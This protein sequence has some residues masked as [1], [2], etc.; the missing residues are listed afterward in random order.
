[1]SSTEENVELIEL[2]SPSSTKSF[3]KSKLK[4]LDNKVGSSPKSSPAHSISKDS[5]GKIAKIPPA[6][7]PR[8]FVRRQ[9]KT[10]TE[11]SSDSQ[12]ESTDFKEY[13]ESI[14]SSKLESGSYRDKFKER[15]EYVKKQAGKSISKA[16]TFKSKGDRIKT[17]KKSFNVIKRQNDIIDAEL[18]TYE[19][20]KFCYDNENYVSSTEAYNF[21]CREQ[22]DEEKKLVES[23]NTLH[24]S[25]D[26]LIDINDAEDVL[27]C[28]PNNLQFN[29]VVS[30]NELFWQP[31]R[32]PLDVVKKIETDEPRFLSEEGFYKKVQ[33]N[34]PSSHINIIEQRLLGINDKKW[35][36]CEGQL[37]LLE[38]PKHEVRYKPHLYKKN[39]EL[40]TKYVK[41]TTDH[42]TREIYSSEAS[43]LDVSL[44]EIK[45]KHHPLFSPE[46]VFAQK[47]LTHFECYKRIIS[48]NKIERISKRLQALR[49]TK[50]NAY[51]ANDSSKFIEIKELREL[52]FTEGRNMRILIKSILQTW[53]ALKKIRH[54]NEYRSTTVQLVI[55]KT[56]ISY[57]S[58]KENWDTNIEN[59]TKEILEEKQIEYENRL[60]EYSRELNQ[61]KQEGDN[62][63]KPRKPS[64]QIDAETI[65]Q[66]VTELFMASFKPPGEPLLHF[67]IKY[68]QQ[69]S[70]KVDNAKEKLRRNVVNT[71]KIYLRVLCDKLEVCKSKIIPLNDQFV[72]TVDEYFSILLQTIPESI[73]VEIYEQPNTLPKRK[74]GEV[75]IRVPKK[76]VFANNSRGLDLDFGRDEI[77][78]YKHDGVGS[79]IELG[80][81]FSEYHQSNETLYTS[82][83]L[84]CKIEWDIKSLGDTLQDHQDIDIGQNV[85]NEDGTLNVDKLIIWANE[86]KPDPE[87]PK[88]SVL[89]EYIQ[90]YGQRFYST[91]STKK[92]FFRKD[93][94]IAPLEFCETKDLEKDLRF[95]L[96]ALRN[97]NEPEFVGMVI[98]NSAKEIPENIFDDYN[99]RIAEEKLGLMLDVENYDD[100]ID[101][102]RLNGRKYLKQVY[103]KVFQQCRN[104]ENNLVYEDVVN[105]KIIPRIEALT[106]NILSNIIS[107]MQL[108]PTKS[109][110]SPLTA[111]KSTT[112][113][114]DLNAPMKIKIDV[115]FGLNVPRRVNV[116]QSGNDEVTVRPFV[117]GTYQNAS[118]QTSSIDGENPVWNQE[119]ILSLDSSNTDYLSPNSLSGCIVIRLFDEVT[120]K[121]RQETVKARNWLGSIE[122]PISSIA[123][124][125]KMDG[126]F[127]LRKPTNLLGYEDLTSPNKERE[128]Y[129]SLRIC[130]E[131][132]IPKLTQSMEELETTELPYL[133]Q[134][135][136]SWNE[137]YNN[138]YPNRK[139][140]AMAIDLNGKTTCVTR[141]IKALEPPH[142]NK[143]RFVV[144]PEQCAQYVAMIPFTDSNK[145]YQNVWMSTEQL[146]KFMIGSVIDHAIALV[147]YL[148]SLDTQSWLL[149]GYGLPHGTT[150]YVLV[151][152]HSRESEIPHHYIYD[153]ITATKYNILDPYCPLQKVFCVINEHNV[154][155]NVQRTDQIEQTRFDFNVKMDW[156]SLFSNQTTAPTHSTQT[157]LT[158]ISTPDTRQ[159]E[160]KVD[161]KIRKKITKVRTHEKTTWNYN[162]SK[163]LKSQIQKF[164]NKNM[165]MKKNSDVTLDVY[166]VTS[167]HFANGY[168][169]NLPYTNIST[170][171]AAIMSTG[172]H[173]YQGLN[174]EFSLAVQIYPYP[175]HVLSV[176]IF[177]AV[178][179][180]K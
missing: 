136:L 125:V 83:V 46:H 80:N 34:L 28:S 55:T 123:N 38:A 85:Q 117:V 1:M 17:L 70:A 81:V 153:I 163:V 30:E 23:E 29:R 164:E 62:A 127:R 73:T 63:K 134:Y 26:V 53:K 16:N 128:T 126:V 124:S 146:L 151:R 47:L 106:R 98:P 110:L 49:H 143:D 61:W 139:F 50:A 15:F 104:T 138:E 105:E 102:K 171:I 113:I 18:R 114:G 68:D 78:H 75:K 142:L 21:F 40:Q 101:E 7:P 160:L 44:L 2:R 69:H 141:Y 140:S 5:D 22:N 45:F 169:L 19:N 77:V 95:R 180:A 51:A 94:D 165:S 24:K 161:R 108:Q 97:Q 172:A 91:D 158:Y 43:I 27:F 112:K 71:T 148:T 20:N 111:K 115:K 174:T 48:E 154:W 152:E 176:W 144:T 72:C 168:L 93:P 64:K 74:L 156:S 12:E 36:D 175:N 60:A 120:V 90:D 87:D 96:L 79:G 9:S 56:K 166:D 122:I 32:N 137:N 149:L 4:L 76:T 129:L 167:T 109:I 41:A 8:K 119:L 121:V 150:A 170:I 130:L 92:T 103:T 179:S 13:T 52:Y 82:G 14:R 86:T 131:P 31:S 57:S 147:C 178:L 6:K 100:E 173:L 135:I 107:W 155:A 39:P 37:D 157:K 88:Y 67:N 59:T 118:L 84:T 10:N 11:I 145:F 99:R 177:L 3:I 116:K 42:T 133:K 33:P 58:E 54:V 66:E 89:Y 162:V 159:L 65:K 132:N 25:T 35:F